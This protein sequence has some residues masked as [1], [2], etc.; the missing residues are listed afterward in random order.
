MQP[1]VM[2]ALQ[3]CYFLNIYSGICDN[4]LLYIIIVLYCNSLT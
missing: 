2:V 1:E 4:D 3:V